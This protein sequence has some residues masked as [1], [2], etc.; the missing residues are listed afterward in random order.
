MPVL[1]DDVGRERGQLRC[2]SAIVVGVAQA[3]AI[4]DLQVAADGP[5]QLLQRL[6]ERG[7]THLHVRILG[8][9]PCSEHA[10]APH[11]AALLRASC[12]RPP[13]R[14]SA[15]KRDE[16]AP[17]HALPSQLRIRPYH[18]AIES[19]VV[20]HSK[21]GPLKT[22]TGQSLHIHKPGASAQCP[23]RPQ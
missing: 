4:I 10:D 9:S 11:R 16:L 13:Y 7:V 12:E 19:G 3:P 14:R 8:R 23:L 5:A 21:F 20:H 1:R 17:P 15:N 18:I 22:A 6:Q 2:V